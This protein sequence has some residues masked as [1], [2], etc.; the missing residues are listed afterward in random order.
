MFK[1]GLRPLSAR[2]CRLL[3]YLGLAV[4]QIAPNARRIFL[5]VEVIYGV[6]TNGER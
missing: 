2:H 6:L 1:A 5:G 3:Q 4:T